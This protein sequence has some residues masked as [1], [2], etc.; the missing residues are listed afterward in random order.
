MKEEKARV[1]AR[2]KEG[3]RAK[4]WLKMLRNWSKYKHLK[5]VKTKRRIRK[6]IPDAVRRQAWG[7]LL[8]LEEEMDSAPSLYAE[9]CV[10]KEG[11]R[12]G[13]EG[14]RDNVFETIE[15]DINRTFPRHVFFRHL[16]EG[17]DRLRRVLQAYARLD[18]EVG[19]C[20]GMG[21]LT[22]LLLTYYPEDEAFHVLRLVM[23]VRPAP[24][25]GLY[26]PGMP[27]AR[28]MIYVGDRLTQRFLPSLHRHLTDQHI[29][30]SMFLTQWF[31][32]LY[33]NCFPFEVVTR[34]WDCFL[35]E[36]WSVIY[37]VQLA[38]LKTH[39]KELLS[40]DFEKVM[41]FFKRLPSLT[42]TAV[43]DSAFRIPLKQE[44][45]SF[46]QAEFHKSRA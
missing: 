4:K 8:G 36:G 38:L 9:S 45:I 2:E 13:E 44:H 16:G 33:T 12:E 42:T 29:D 27:T 32:T 22:A 11:E 24:I 10:V 37:S 28:E 25:R 34:I 30:P 17:Q 40:R 15:R 26:L 41:E 35:A 43:M 1:Q 5:P 19:Y 20:Q 31:V 18:P 3:K 46:Y 7:L 23:C 14:R 6:G 39:E 21:F